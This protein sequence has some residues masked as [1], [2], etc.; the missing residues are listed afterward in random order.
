MLHTLWKKKQADFDIFYDNFIV[1]IGRELYVYFW[2]SAIVVYIY[3]LEFGIFTL[4]K[5]Y[6]NIYEE[7]LLLIFPLNDPW[8][9]ACGNLC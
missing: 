7:S 1:F 5:H 6:F 9:F 2:K 4:T 8:K 3:D